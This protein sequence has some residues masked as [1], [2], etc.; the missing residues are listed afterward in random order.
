MD[1]NTV[2]LFITLFTLQ[3]TH[4]NCLTFKNIFY[5]IQQAFCYTHQSNFPF[6][7]N[8]NFLTAL[9]TRKEF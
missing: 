1:S 7:F 9:L 8:L 5:N 2:H 6:I 3:D 4:P